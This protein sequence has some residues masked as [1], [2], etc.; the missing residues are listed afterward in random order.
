MSAK[1]EQGILDLDLCGCRDCGRDARGPK[2][3]R[4][5]IIRKLERKA[6]YVGQAFLPVGR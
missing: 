1:R 4:I 2:I 3:G 6:G 5:V